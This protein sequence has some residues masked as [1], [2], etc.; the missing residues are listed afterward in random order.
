MDRCREGRVCEKDMRVSRMRVQSYSSS[1]TRRGRLSDYK[2]AMFEGGGGAGPAV[3]ATG[4]NTIRAIFRKSCVSLIGSGDIHI[5]AARLS[6]SILDGHELSIG[7][8]Y[9]RRIG[10]LVGWM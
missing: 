10:W 7:G 5:S 3:L 8:A 4:C 1:P 9:K 6:L 2:L